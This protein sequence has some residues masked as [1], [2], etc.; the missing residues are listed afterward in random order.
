LVTGR[1][2]WSLW[3]WKGLSGSAISG[4]AE[5]AFLSSLSTVFSLHTVNLTIH[6]L[7]GCLALVVGTLA[8][9][10]RKRVG[11]HTRLGRYFLYLLLVVVG[12]G[13]LG[14]LFF[15]TNGFLLML[16]MLSG[17]VGYA[18]Y[19]T[20]QLR[21][22][23]S[24]SFDAGLALTMLVVSTVYIGWL[25]QSGLSW[26]PT[27][28]YS[29]WSALVLVSGYDLLKHFWWHERLKGAW[30]YEHIY[31][32]ISAYSAL[33][34]AFVGTLLPQ[35]KPYS[36]VGPSAFCLLLIGYQIWRQSRKRR[37]L[38]SAKIRVSTKR[39]AK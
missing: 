19:R 13:L 5:Q 6:V 16:T 20:V 37:R 9:L 8:L 25:R 14:A 30:L 22:K 10:A 17:Y 3:T 26:S 28:V 35:F 15:R 12:T 18:G 39:M 11:R 33:L 23:R 4:I 21:E 1:R 2:P 24:A 27:V 7:F 38:D 31:K 29:T 32:M 34:S 36:Q